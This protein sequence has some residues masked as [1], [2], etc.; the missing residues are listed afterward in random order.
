MKDFL[1]K[2]FC[3]L[4]F[5]FVTDAELIS[6]L[7]TPEECVVFE[8][9]VI[10]RDRPDLALAARKRAIEL[11]ALAHNANT[12]AERECIEAVYAYEQILSDKNGKNT[13]AT[14][15]WQMIKRHGLIVAVERAVNREA[16]AM[17]YRAL[18]EK[19]LENYAFESIVVRYPTLF[20]PKAVQR[21]QARLDEHK[22]IQQ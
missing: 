12:Q 5:K 20:S 18:L 10:E 6:K 15:T 19:G 4:K 21:S 22:Q 14:R 2:I 17:G 16:E 11:R 7:K 13:R 9:N 1:D 8:K 3:R